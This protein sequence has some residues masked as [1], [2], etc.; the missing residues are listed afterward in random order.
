MESPA[1]S[2]SSLRDRFD[3]N[4][5]E[6]HSSIHPADIRLTDRILARIRRR[7]DLDEFEFQPIRVW[8]LSPLGVEL[9]Q[10]DE[11]IP[12]GKGDPVDLEITL[13]GQR[14]LFEGLVVDLVQA[15]DSIELIGIRLSKRK[16]EDALRDERRRATRWLCSDEFFPTCMAPT[17]GR[18]DDF[19][20]LQIRDI[21]NEGLQLVCSL[22]NKFLIA[23]MRLNLM[24]VF[25]MGSVT[26]VQVEITRVGITSIGARDKL[27]LG[28]KF[29]DLSRTAR[30]AIGQYLVQFGEV[31][32]LEELRLAGLAPRSLSLGVDFYN[33]KK[34][35]DYKEVLELRRLAHELDGNLRQPV[36]AVD[37][38]DIYDARARIVVG[39]FRGR[40]VATARIRYNELNDPLEHEAHVTWPKELPRRDQIIEVSRVATHPDFRKNDLL[41][42]LFRFICH[43]VVQPE[44]PWLIMSC[45]D[46]MVPYYEKIGFR[47]TGLRHTEPI[48]KDDRVL[49]VMICNISE[50][51][52]GRNVD[53]FYWNLIW[54]EL[55]LLL[56]DQKAIVPSG[57]DKVRIRIYKSIGPL[58]D[59]ALQLRR[60][61]SKTKR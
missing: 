13:A 61:R 46:R 35:D 33:L 15:A 10:P 12:F 51:V 44:R 43:N 25:P 7:S 17:P 16:V 20:Y 18:F 2:G 55:S 54:K 57:M 58:A 52:L 24:A 45:L 14:T 48:W 32:S 41:A 19:V 29:V 6:I 40:I 47:R 4:F 21:S 22:R 27:V 31:E 60:P 34:E 36:A 8:K 26:N 42:A 50:L 5:D 53:P 59:L 3:R 37:M 9:V 23:G 11:E 38:G 56:V 49:N 39:K 28:T 1:E 30:Q